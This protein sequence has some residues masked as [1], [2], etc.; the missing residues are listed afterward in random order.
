[1]VAHCTPKQV[2]LPVHIS[3]CGCVY[4]SVPLE[5]EPPDLSLPP[6]NF[7]F[8]NHSECLPYLHFLHLSVVKWTEQKSSLLLLTRTPE[9]ISHAISH[10]EYLG[11]TYRWPDIIRLWIDWISV[12]LVQWRR[13][14]AFEKKKMGEWNIGKSTFPF[15]FDGNFRRFYG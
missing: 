10:F 5:Y 7:H 14:R 15:L 2:Q 3:V 13:L 12:R 4:P 9:R 8:A 11:L 6:A 1:M